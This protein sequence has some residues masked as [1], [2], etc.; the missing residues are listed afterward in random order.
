MTDCASLTT[1]TQTRLLQPTLQLHQA[2][3]KAPSIPPIDQAFA[4]LAASEALRLLSASLETLVHVT[5]DIPPTPPPRSPTD[6]QM[7]GL[8][9]EKDIIARSRRSSPAPGK[10][11]DRVNR[12]KPRSQ[13]QIADVSVDRSRKTNTQQPEI[14][15]VRLKSPSLRAPEH[16]IISGDSRP[17]NTQ[18]S[19]ITR[20]FYS[21]LEP[22]ITITQYLLRLHQFCPMSTAVYIATSLYIHRLAVEQCAIHV[23]RRNVH[24][25][26]LAGLR[27]ATKA[28]EDL[29]YPHS[30]VAKVG[31]VS[32]AE[33]A[34][35]EIS[36]CFLAGFELVIGEEMLRTHCEV[37]KEK[38]D[39]ANKRQRGSD[40]KVLELR[41]ANKPNGAQES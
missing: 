4:R 22:P 15:G 2:T 31:G 30:K 8:Q 27:V 28:L 26:V 6:P 3:T 29:A 32:E 38:S 17:L 20:K 16:I 21:K 36:F 10:A 14:D 18:H 40:E 5:G 41:M 23:T 24:R 37:L 25:L 33:L 9:A 39:E 12:N 35:L 19:A 11:D 13:D 7:S 34:R 1:T